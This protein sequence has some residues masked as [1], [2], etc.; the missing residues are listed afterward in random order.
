MRS[1]GSGWAIGNTPIG[2]DFAIYRWN[3]ATRAWQQVSGQA[4]TLSV[5]LNGVP[6]IVNAAHE[7]YKWDG[8]SSWKLFGGGSATCGGDGPCPTSVASGSSDDETWVIDKKSAVWNWN[9]TTW[10]QPTTAAGSKIMVQSTPDPVCGD[11]LPMVL[12]SS[13]IYAFEHSVASCVLSEGTFADTLGAG[14]DITTQFAMGAD[15]KIYRWDSVLSHWSF[16]G[17]TPAGPDWGKSTKIGA[18][19]NGLFAL[20][21]T[22]AVDFMPMVPW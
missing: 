19:A 16:Y 8:V 22:G 14:P 11:H 21:S 10:T 3:T 15:G 7:I 2:A 12:G 13:T 9:G 6:F 18:L 17:E 5:N 4:Q 20:S 1:I